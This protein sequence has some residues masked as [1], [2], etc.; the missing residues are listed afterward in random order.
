MTRQ[1]RIDSAEAGALFLLKKPVRR[2]FVRPGRA[3]VQYFGGRADVLSLYGRDDCS[4]LFSLARTER[5]YRQI[6][7]THPKTQ[8]KEEN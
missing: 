5:A 2:R 4:L 6:P 7:I 3:G 1:V 8:R